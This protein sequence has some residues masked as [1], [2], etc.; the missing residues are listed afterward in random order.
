MR[1]QTWLGTL[2]RD[3]DK[4]GKYYVLFMRALKKRIRK[5]IFPH[6]PKYEKENFFSI[7]REQSSKIPIF[8]SLPPRREKIMPQYFEYHVLFKRSLKKRIRKFIFPHFPKYEKE[9]FFSIIREQ[10]SKIP[11]F[12]SLPPRKGENNATVLRI[13]CPLQEALKKMFRKFLCGDFPKDKKKDNFFTTI[14]EQSSKTPIIEG[15]VPLR[16]K[17]LRHFKY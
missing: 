7:I 13:P 12:E 15:L 16:M 5:F 1:L 9:N 17:K 3:V 4:R 8:E 2:H 14:R 10:S 6:F 11:I